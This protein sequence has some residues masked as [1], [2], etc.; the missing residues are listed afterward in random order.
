M[1]YAMLNHWTID[2]VSYSSYHF[3][4]FM[5]DV[6]VIDSHDCDLEIHSFEFN[7]LFL[8]GYRQHILA[9]TSKHR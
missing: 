8:I 1:E 7:Y 9:P 5:L 6:H 3:I 4:V 2:R